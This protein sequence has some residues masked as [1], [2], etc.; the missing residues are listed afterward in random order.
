MTNSALNRTT[1]LQLRNK[2]GSTQSQGAV[3]I[4]DT[5]NEKAFTTTTTASYTST[6]IGVVT[7]PA[8]I[9][10]NAI[11]AV[12]FAGWVP[13]I[14]L[15]TSASTGS[16]ISTTTVAGQ[17][18]PSSQADAGNFAEALEAGTTPEAYLYG[19]TTQST[20]AT[21][22]DTTDRYYDGSTG[23]KLLFQEDIP[24]LTSGILTSK[25][26]GIVGN[27]DAGGAR[28]LTFKIYI[29]ADPATT[30]SMSLAAS[31]DYNYLLEN[32]LIDNAGTLIA[33][34]RIMVKKEGNATVTDG[35]T[36]ID[37]S[38]S[39]GGLANTTHTYKITANLSDADMYVEAYGTLIEGPFYR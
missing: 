32:A 27:T 17:G 1:I 7:E 34:Y 33:N 31:T 20:G 14:N 37:T 25:T 12:A 26:W 3:V 5:A 16:L 39:F 2:S 36:D 29:D 13:K 24:I 15:S 30:A 6:Q 35:F 21:I 11:G 10:S 9:A 4:L 18:V 23:E 19:Y 22:V 28:T 8:G 38:F